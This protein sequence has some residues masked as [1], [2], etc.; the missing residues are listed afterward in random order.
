VTAPDTVSL[1]AVRADDALLD[2][3]GG[4]TPET[5]P[6]AVTDPLSALLVA[7]L[8]EVDSRPVGVLVDTDTAL[9]AIT[10]P[11]RLARLWHRVARFFTRRT[12]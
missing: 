2:V 8:R 11:T 5:A 9:T 12:R 1:A 4:R 3:L 10:R 7:W 6:T